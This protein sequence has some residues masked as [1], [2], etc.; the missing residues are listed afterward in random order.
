MPLTPFAI[1]GAGWRSEFFLRIARAL[2][3]RF[4][5]CGMVVRNEAKGQAVERAWDLP[6]FRTLDALLQKTAPRFVIVSV[7]WDSNPEVVKDLARR[8]V[9]S[10]CETPPAPD[11]PRL[12]ELCEALDKLHAKAQY[13]EQVALRPHHQAQ[14]AIARSGKLGRV[15]QAQVSVAHGYHGISVMRKFLGVCYEPC[16][17]AGRTFTSPVIQGPGRDGPPKQETIKDSQQKLAFFDYGDRLGFFDFTGD[18]YFHSIRNERVLVRGERGEIVNRTVHYLKDH[19]TTV[20]QDLVRHETGRFGELS[21]PHLRGIQWGDDWVYRNPFAPAVLM[22][23]E[24]AIAEMMAG[25]D[26]YIDEGQEFYG[27]PEGCQ[28]HYLA[29]TM[30]QAIKTGQPVQATRQPWARATPLSLEGRGGGGEGAEAPSAPPRG[31]GL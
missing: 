17:I 11:V 2:P 7:S 19:L 23:D 3:E 18:Q 9:P 10:L 14:L 22:D 29:L 20:T 8:G 12:I 15:T 27:I 26:A 16:T 21:A 24:I 13:L 4:A 6:T 25:M 5:C 1:V 28:D 30:D 31:K